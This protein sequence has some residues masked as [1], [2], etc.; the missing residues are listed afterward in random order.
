MYTHTQ[1]LDFHLSTP[2]FWSYSSFS[3]LRSS[4]PICDA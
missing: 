1:T 3:L 2:S 4:S